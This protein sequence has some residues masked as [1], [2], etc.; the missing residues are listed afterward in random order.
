MLPTPLCSRMKGSEMSQWTDDNPGLGDADHLRT[1]SSRMD[2]ILRELDH[3][4]GQVRDQRDAVAGTWTGA[5]AEAYIARLDAWLAKV[6]TLIDGL[7]PYSGGARTYGNAIEDI[8]DAATSAQS[9]LATAVQVAA[10]ANTMLTTFPPPGVTY[11]PKQLRQ[12]QS[13]RSDAR[14]DQSRLTR[15]LAELV[16][17]RSAADTT[18]VAAIAAVDIETWSSMGAAMT[19]SGMTTLEELDTDVIRNRMIWL[20]DFVREGGSELTDELNTLLGV[21]GDDP[22]FMR[23]F[24]ET[25]GGEGL[26]DLMNHLDAQAIAG[27]P[28]SAAEV[29]VRLRGGLS[30]ASALWDEQQAQD[31]ADAM[32]NARGASA[33]A[34]A[35]LFADPVN[36]PMSPRLAGAAANA[37]QQ[38]EI[39]HGRPFVWQ[40]PNLPGGMTAE[41]DYWPLGEGQHTVDPAAYIFDQLRLD[42]AAATDWLGGEGRA[43]YWYGERA[44]EDAGGFTSP[45]RLW[46]DIQGVPGALAGKSDYDADLAKA[47]AEVNARILSSWAERDYRGYIDPVNRP[48]LLGGS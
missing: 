26:I 21:W 20:T 45:M 17:D 19:A 16:A 12:A 47:L 43:E 28:E 34:V 23:D 39:E 25:L 11:T 41:L 8:D 33:V 48:G 22:I 14:A 7:T 4:R 30:A 35:Y 31:L 38:W 3:A 29:L 9:D 36:A 1:R 15:E 6:E 32:V 42:P 46:E 13:D 37:I 5:S 44:W 10:T 40:G 2:T 18:F 24:Y 27:E